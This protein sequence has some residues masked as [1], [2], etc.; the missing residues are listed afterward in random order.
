MIPLNS[1]EKSVHAGT[2]EEYI[3][4]NFMNENRERI[5]DLSFFMKLFRDTLSLFFLVSSYW[6]SGVSLFI[7]KFLDELYEE[8]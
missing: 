7:L 4:I 3:R 5:S 8:G 2:G 1:S 6:N